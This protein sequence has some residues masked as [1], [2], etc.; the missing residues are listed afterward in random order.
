MSISVQGSLSKMSIFP[1]M[2]QS[3]IR[4]DNPL[5][6]LSHFSPLHPKGRYDEQLGLLGRIG[7]L[8]Y[9]RKEMLGLMAMVFCT[10]KP[11]P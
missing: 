9:K 4:L 8:A 6:L 2:G 3:R 1:A 7:G 11:S 10:H 5:T